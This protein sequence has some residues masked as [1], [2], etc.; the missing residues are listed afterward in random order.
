[1]G[2]DTMSTGTV[3]RMGTSAP[4]WRRVLFRLFAHRYFRR[5]LKTADGSC[6]VYVTAGA[7]LS[8]LHP[9]GVRI[10]PVHTRFI[11]RWVKPDSVIWDVGANMGLFA[12][13]AALKAH[14]GEVYT[15]EP[16]SE[17]ASNLLRSLRRPASAGLRVTLMPFALSDRDELANFLI[18]AHGTSMNK[19]AGVGEWH[20][21][22]FQAE[23][24]RT[25][26]TLRIDT[27]AR[28]LRPPDIIKID[29]EGAEMRVLEGGRETISKARPVMLIE[30]PQELADAM[31]AYLDSLDY[32]IVDGHKETEELINHTVWDT[33]AIPREKWNG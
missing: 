26:V 23:E 1:M 20:D 10:D 16:D 5:R 3:S 9:C 22:I 13:P 32:L 15:F 28:H 4:R 33:V 25:V 31:K 27:V 24:S 14:K 17:L 2:A 18:A 11:A 12:L 6:D 8:V 29:V 7:Q 19:L 30:G 21:N